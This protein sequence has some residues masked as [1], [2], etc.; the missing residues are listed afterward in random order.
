MCR[1]FSLLEMVSSFIN[2]SLSQLLGLNKSY[3]IFHIFSVLYTL[4]LVIQYQ[5]CKSDTS[6]LIPIEITPPARKITPPISSQALE[7]ADSQP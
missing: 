5:V 7:V 1:L 2:T 3:C 4:D 6:S